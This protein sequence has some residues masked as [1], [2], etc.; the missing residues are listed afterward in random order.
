MY[1]VKKRFIFTLPAE[2]IK[3]RKQTI[4]HYITGYYIKA[5]AP[6]KA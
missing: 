1:K 3:A 6:I 4:I 5:R 2:D